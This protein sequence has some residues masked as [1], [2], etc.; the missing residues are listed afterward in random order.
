[1]PKNKD[2][3]EVNESEGGD[4]D[5]KKDGKGENTDANDESDDDSNE[6]GASSVFLMNSSHELP[7]S[8]CS[9]IDSTEFYDLFIRSTHFSSNEVMGSIIH[10]IRMPRTCLVQSV[11][12]HFVTDDR[13]ANKNKLAITNSVFYDKTIP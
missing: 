10:R 12:L 5:I 3:Q 4:D 7:S 6:S 13:R 1:M 2:K 8:S 11:P 9:F